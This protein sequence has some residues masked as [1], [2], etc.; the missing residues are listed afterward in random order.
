M[1]ESV[2][3]SKN[4]SEVV[5]EI[6]NIIKS[7][8]RTFEAKDFGKLETFIGADV[9]QVASSYSFLDRQK[10]DIHSLR[11]SKLITCDFGL[12]QS[13]DK[14]IEDSVKDKVLYKQSN[15]KERHSIQSDTDGPLGQSIIPYPSATFTIKNVAHFSSYIAY[16]R[17]LRDNSNPFAMPERRFTEL[18]RLTIRLAHFLVDF[19]TPHLAISGN[20][21]ADSLAKAAS[22]EKTSEKMLIPYTDY[23]KT[24]KEHQLAAWQEEYTTAYERSVLRGSGI[25]ISEDLTVNRYNKYKS[26]SKKVGPGNVWVRD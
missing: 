23:L 5:A 11:L 19:L 3:A 22:C 24:L 1:P 18:F 8:K 21:V 25:F 9:T 17:Q 12:P 20:E 15:L 14:D 2:S 16:R 6:D 4:K 10:L 7:L 13:T 26:V